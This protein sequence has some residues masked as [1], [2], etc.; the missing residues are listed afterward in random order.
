MS[1]SDPPSRIHPLGG[2]VNAFDIGRE[3]TGS[4]KSLAYMLPLVQQCRELE[5]APRRSSR[6][7]ARPA[8][9]FRTGI[10][11]VYGFDSIRI[12]FERGEAKSPK[13]QAT[14]QGNSTRRILVCEL[15][16]CEMAVVI[17]H[18]ELRPIRELSSWSFRASTQPD[19]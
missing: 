3:E 11:P 8:A 7:L 14:P 16:V 4:G 1:W 15:L 10:L 13:T 18:S 9:A 17:N 2:A 5:Q 6:G 19:A 12:V